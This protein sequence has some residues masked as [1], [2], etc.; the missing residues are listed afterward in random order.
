MCFACIS[1]FCCIKRWN[2][3]KQPFFYI[4]QFLRQIVCFGSNPVFGW[5]KKA[6]NYKNNR[7]LLISLW[8]LYISLFSSILSF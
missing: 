5:K 3:P 4:F 1:E 8:F 6:E 7:F 2:T